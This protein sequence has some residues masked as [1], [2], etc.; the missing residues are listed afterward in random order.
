[1][2]IY[3]ELAKNLGYLKNLEPEHNGVDSFLSTDKMKISSMSDLLNFSRI[4]NDTLVHKSKKDLWKISED[5]KGDVV[6]E[7]LFDPDTNEAIRV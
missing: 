4:G 7:R 3:H 6:I 1:M 5:D 2:D